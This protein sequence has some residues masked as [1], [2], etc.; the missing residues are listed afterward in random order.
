MFFLKGF[1][2]HFG[3]SFGT[4]IEEKSIQKRDVKRNDTNYENRILASTKSKCSSSEVLK[5]L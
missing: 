1:C 3:E 4:K 5:N 2:K